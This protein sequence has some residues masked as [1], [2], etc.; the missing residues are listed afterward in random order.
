MNLHDFIILM[1]L[2]IGTSGYNEIQHI[3]YKQ[4]HFEVTNTSKLPLNYEGIILTQFIIT[5]LCH[6]IIHQSY[7]IIKDGSSLLLLSRSNGVFS[8]FYSS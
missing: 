8:Q 2:L 3:I 6:W 5:S 1:I 4:I 7:I